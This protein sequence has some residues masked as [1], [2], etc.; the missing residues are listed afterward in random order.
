MVHSFNEEKFREVV[1]KGI[2]TANVVS[3]EA[4]AAIEE[5]YFRRKGMGISTFIM[6][7]LGISLYLTI[8]RIERRQSERK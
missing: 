7:I 5:Y 6:T 1:S 3:N 2:T 8:R 4:N